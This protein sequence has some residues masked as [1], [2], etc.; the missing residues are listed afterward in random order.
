VTDEEIISRVRNNTSDDVNELP[1]LKILEFAGETYGNW[2]SGALDIAGVTADAW[3]YLARKDRYG[4]TS[5]GAVAASQPVS[6]LQA[7]Y[8]LSQSKK[9][10]GIALTQATLTRTDL[11]AVPE[12]AEFNG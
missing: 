8:W 11:V 6:W 7:A 2:H 12:D 3:I 5:A 4:A 10:S 9:G 1:D